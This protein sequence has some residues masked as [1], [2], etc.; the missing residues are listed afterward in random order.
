MGEF[1]ELRGR[2]AKEVMGALN[3]TRALKEAGVTPATTQ[4]DS[5]QAAAAVEQLDAWIA[6]AKEN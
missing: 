6:K 5:I 2:T 3:A 1:A 4:Y